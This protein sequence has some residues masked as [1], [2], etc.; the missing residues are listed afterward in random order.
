MKSVIVKFN[1]I[2]IFIG[3]VGMHFMNV[4][5]FYKVFNNKHENEFKVI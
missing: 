5:K 2:S 3:W 4:S 1:Y